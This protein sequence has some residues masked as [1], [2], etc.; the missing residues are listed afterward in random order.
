M[1]AYILANGAFPKKKFLINE[2]KN[3]PFIIVCD[4]AIAHID[5]LG[6]KVDVIIGDL[7][8]IDK[9]L[10]EKY[11]EKIV[12]IQEQ[13]SNDLSKAFYY[14]LN[15]GFNEFVIL[16][17]TGKREDHTLGNISLLL[18]YAKACKNVIMKSDYGEFEVVK[19]PCKI[20]SVKGQQISI[21]C[22]DPHIKISSKN[23]KY[24]LKNL[25]LPLLASATLNEALKD[26]FYIKTDKVC[27][28]LIYKKY[29]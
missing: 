28:L 16:G 2:L 15:L 12:Y 7:D 27:K 17:A 21:F 8:S 5:R 14:G 24:P 13:M 1:K 6:I 10:K 25:S 11:F 23:L 22:F 26:N 9:K 19:T 20:S 4:G 3:A 18:L 29:I